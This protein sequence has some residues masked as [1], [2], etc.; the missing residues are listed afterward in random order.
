[1]SE[2][3]FAGCEAVWR[4]RLQ[5]DTAPHRTGLGHR[6]FFGRNQAVERSTAAH[7]DGLRQLLTRL[8]RRSSEAARLVDSRVPSAF[9]RCSTKPAALIKSRVHAA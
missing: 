3:S 2:T 5:T 8:K 6:S 1:M 9:V 4:A 7:D